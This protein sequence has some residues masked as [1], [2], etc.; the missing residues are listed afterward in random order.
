[1]FFQVFPM[2]GFNYFFCMKLSDYAADVFM[3]SS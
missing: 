3:F 2:S 1:M